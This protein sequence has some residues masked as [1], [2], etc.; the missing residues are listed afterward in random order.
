MLREEELLRPDGPALR[1]RHL[2]VVHARRE[3]RPRVLSQGQRLLL[4]AA[5]C[6]A[7]T[8]EGA[9][10][11]LLQAAESLPGG[12]LYVPERCRDCDGKKCCKASE[13]C[14]WCETSDEKDQ[15]PL[16]GLKCCPK[17]KPF[18]CG[19]TCCQ[20]GNCCGKKCCPEGSTCA[21]PELGGALVCCPQGRETLVTDPE[22]GDSVWVCCSEGSVG[23][24]SGGCCPPGQNEC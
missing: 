21:R 24:P 22:S 15:T 10:A 23:V 13:T 4:S 5:E 6:Q 16:V 3:V 7:A 12:Y 1:A 19:S 20:V 14:A 11:R 9:Q 17:S 2:R 8:A 18:C